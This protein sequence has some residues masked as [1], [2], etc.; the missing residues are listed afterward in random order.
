MK[1]YLAAIEPHNMPQAS[2]ILLSYYDIA[3]SG[4]PFRMGTWKLIKEKEYESESSRIT[5]GP[6]NGKACPGEQGNN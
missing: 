6:G 1:I 5:K 2:N 4:I 3:L